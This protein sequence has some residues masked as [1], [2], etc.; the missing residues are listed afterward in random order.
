MTEQEI[1]AIVNSKLNT[2]TDNKGYTYK[3]LLAV[4]VACFIIGLIVGS[5]L[6]K[7][8]WPTLN[9]EVKTVDSDPI[10]T[11]KVKVVTDTQIAYVPKE[12]I[13]YIDKATGQQV[14]AKE[15]TD[16]QFDVAKAKVAVKVNGQDHEFDLLQGETQK[17]QDGKVSMQQTSTV[18]LD[19]KIPTIDLTR[20]NV[21]TVG[22]MYTD[23][24][25]N[26]AIGYTGSVGRIGA[27]Q[28]VASKGGQY[29][30]VGIKF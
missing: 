16:V 2:S 29:A 14:T 7:N 21:L 13:H 27:Y 20:H 8:Y 28:I 4:S 12:T 22:A 17:F 5:Y 25:I 1:M 30:G 10:V 3:T 6:T 9:T 11:E 26:H 18:G 15:S 23:G 19:I 24:Q